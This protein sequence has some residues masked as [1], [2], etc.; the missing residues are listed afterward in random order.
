MNHSSRQ[1]FRFYN[2]EAGGLRPEAIHLIVEAVAVPLQ[3]IILIGIFSYDLYL[4][5][6]YIM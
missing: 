6:R 2:T 5:K 1:K 4:L 3:T